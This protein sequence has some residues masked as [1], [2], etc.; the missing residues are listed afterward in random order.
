MVVSGNKKLSNSSVILI[1]KQ[2]KSKCLD[3]VTN[4]IQFGHKLAHLY[5][6]W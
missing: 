2:N 5:Q 3:S 6:C 1:K 4:G